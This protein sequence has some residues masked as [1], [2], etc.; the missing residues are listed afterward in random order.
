MD[1]TCIHRL[2]VSADGLCPACQ[3]DYDTDPESWIEFGDHP[4][5]IANWKAEQELI[6]QWEREQAARP[7]VECDPEIPF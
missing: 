5:G 7:P 3:E 6:A 4:Q 2:S 1:L